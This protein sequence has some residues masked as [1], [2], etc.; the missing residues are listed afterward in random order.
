M[1]HP[2]TPF[3]PGVLERAQEILHSTDDIRIL[4]SMQAIVLREVE[5]MSSKQVSAAVGLS[6]GWVRGWWSTVGRQ[7]MRTFDS[8]QDHRGGRRHAHLTVEEETEFLKPFI[9]A[10]QQSGILIVN[11]IH[12]AYEAKVGKEVKPMTVYRILHRHGWRK[13]APR[14]QHPKAD[15]EAQKMFKAILFPPGGHASAHHGHSLAT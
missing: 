11:G 13:I 6:V 5:H 12:Q 9:T 15:P 7:G 4:R 3:S 8:L 10:A 2:T 1:A 14:P